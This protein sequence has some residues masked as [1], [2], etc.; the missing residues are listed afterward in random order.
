MTTIKWLIKCNVILDHDVNIVGVRS[1]I[2]KEYARTKR[3]GVGPFQKIAKHFE[4]SDL[5]KIWKTTFCIVSY[6]HIYIK[7]SLW[8]ICSTLLYTNTPVRI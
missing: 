3:M 7:I 1:A 6:Q 8:E 5:N 2:E 4:V